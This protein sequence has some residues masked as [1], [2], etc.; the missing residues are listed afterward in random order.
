MHQALDAHQ[1][2]AEL[3]ARMQA[4]RSP[5]ARKPFSTSSVIASASPIASAAV[6]L[7]VGT[8]FIGHASS[9]TLQSS[10]TS[11]ACA[12]VERGVA[13]DRDQ[14]RAEPADGLEQAQDLVGLAAVRQRDDDVVGLDDAEIAVDRFGRVQEER[15]PCRC[16]SASRRSS[17]R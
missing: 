4:A 9:V 10:A 7:A 16:S 8:R 14:L 2:L 3:A 13:G 12:S 11:A 5:P 17:G 6:V 15:R 1:P